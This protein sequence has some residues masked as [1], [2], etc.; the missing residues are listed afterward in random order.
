MKKYGLLFYFCMVAPQLLGYKTSMGETLRNLQLEIDE[1][2]R[3]SAL[4]DGST[5]T[6]S[7]GS[8]EVLQNQNNPVLD[9][10]KLEKEDVAISDSH[11]ESVGPVAPEITEFKESNEKEWLFAVYMAGKNNL[12]K[13]VGLNIKGM[14]DAGSGKR[15]HVVAQI[16]ELGKDEITRVH[17]Q[18]KKVKVLEEHESTEEYMSGTVESLYRFV[19]WATEHFPSKKICIVV[20]DHGSG[21]IDPHMW[22]RAWFFDKDSDV[23]NFNVDTGLLELRPSAHTMRDHFEKDD[24]RGIAFNEEESVYLTNADLTEVVERIQD[25]LLGGEKIDLLVFDAC[26]MSMI[27]VA[28]QI[29]FSVEYMV[30]SEE[31]A[32]GKGLPY[33][34]ILNGLNSRSLS[35]SDFATYITNAYADEYE[36]TFADF[37]LSAI[38]LEKMHDLK[39]CMHDIATSLLNLVDSEYGDEFLDMLY[40]I[41]VSRKMSTAFY[42]RDYIDINHTLSSIKDRVSRFKKLEEVTDEVVF[43][44]RSI[45]EAQ[46]LIEEMVISNVHGYNPVKA[47]GLSMYWP[48]SSLHSSYQR[49]IFG[50]TT[51]WRHLIQRYLT[52]V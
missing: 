43:L 39:L 47:S 24:E 30:S 9:V 7:T 33:K 13:F 3:S 27:E 52:S 44:Q 16:D 17:V 29:N 25:D 6:T 14:A 18:K 4:P 49:S 11:E 38:N 21:A 1:E 28:C 45:K 41:R 31:I 26:M 15:V 40:A 2:V 37:T 51:K 19:E 48:R 34:Q 50:K 23:F 32:P 8:E 46:N 22:D 36:D 20:W 10:E 5:D 42:N 12:S 35:S